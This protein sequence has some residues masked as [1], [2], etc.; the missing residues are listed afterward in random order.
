MN[1]EIKNV[2]LK[3]T[4]IIHDNP[5]SPRSPVSFRKRLSILPSSSSTAV[6]EE[7]QPQEQEQ[8]KQLFLC[9]NAND[10]YSI[11]TLTNDIIHQID[12]I[13]NEML[14]KQKYDR[15]LYAQ[16]Q[17][18]ILDNTSS[19]TFVPKDVA[20]R[21]PQRIRSIESNLESYGTNSHT[22]PIDP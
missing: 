4:V 22:I 17:R 6:L 13:H 3:T 7:I 18:Q 20:P 2:L 1:N 5:R 16:N 14:Q 11:A 9:N 12:N 15:F 19:V 10:V 21:M 8:Q